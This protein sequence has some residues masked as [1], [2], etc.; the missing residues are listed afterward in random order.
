[1]SV[2]L[3][4]VTRGEQDSLLK[5]HRERKLKF[6]VINDEDDYLFPMYQYT[7]GV[8]VRVAIL[9]KEGI[10]RYYRARVDKYFIESIVKR[11]AALQGED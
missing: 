3:K 11:Y 8:C 7:C 6:A 9:D 5:L 1:L 10:V 4:F 2:D